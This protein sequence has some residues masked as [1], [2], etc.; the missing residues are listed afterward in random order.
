MAGSAAMKMRLL[1]W[2][3]LAPLLASAYPTIPHN[4]SFIS[5][6]ST[7][8]HITNFNRVYGHYIC[9]PMT[10]PLGQL[11]VFLGGTGTNDYTDFVKVASELG[12]HSISLDWINH[13]CAVA[14][15]GMKLKQYTCNGPVIP[16]ECEACTIALQRTRLMG[17]QAPNTSNPV[18]TVDSFNSILGRTEAA[19]SYLTK[20]EPALRWE[21]FLTQNGSLR[22]E[23]TT[24]SGHSRGSSYPPLVSKLFKARRV[25]S[26][27]GIADH[28]GSTTNGT[29]L[30]PTWLREPSVMSVK[31]V[32]ALNP[33][34]EGTQPKAVD[35]HTLTNGTT[36]NATFGLAD[37]QHLNATLGGARIL[38]DAEICA[39]NTSPHMCIGTCDGW[40]PV[41]KATN[42]PLLAPVWKYLLL[43]T[44]EPSAKSLGT[45]IKD[46]IPNW[47]PP[48]CTTASG[49]DSIASAPHTGG[50]SCFTD[51]D[52]CPS[53][54]RNGPKSSWGC[55]NCGDW[56]GHGCAACSE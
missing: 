24:V 40:Q 55:K 10:A 6:A 4:C 28:T 9:R 13:P 22:W 41:D 34:F 46:S 18:Q 16:P 31:D 29:M 50:A 38:W 44:A 43:N 7:S 54:A 48:N 2:G 23:V 8:P 56:G 30:A 35:Y 37:L 49:S 19:L 33:G 52:L 47:T 51:P 27:G 14:A 5:A 21:Q 11:L 17:S 36:G 3:L 1:C 53:C 15:C 45:R 42:R 25:I 26:F 32:Y 12:F 39:N 20:T